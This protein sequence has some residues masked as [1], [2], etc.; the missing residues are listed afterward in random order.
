MSLIQPVILLHLAIFGGLV[1]SKIEELNCLSRPSPGGVEP[2]APRL[3]ST[4][5]AKYVYRGDFC[6]LIDGEDGKRYLGM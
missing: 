4:F 6:P 3:Q 1:R 2:P 5:L